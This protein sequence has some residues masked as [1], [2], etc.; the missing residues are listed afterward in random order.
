MASNGEAATANRTAATGTNAK[1]RIEEGR[2]AVI[3]VLQGLVGFDGFYVP[4][5][6]AL[7]NE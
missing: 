6:G 2:L 1:V 7:I 5:P 4:P 3:G